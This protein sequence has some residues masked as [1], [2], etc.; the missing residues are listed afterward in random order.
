MKVYIAE[1]E[2]DH[3]GFTILGA[4]S[5]MEKAQEACDNDKYKDGG[6]RG[7]SHNIEEFEI[8]A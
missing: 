1:R 2:Y 7:D 4:F 6:K 3:E 8:D 5:T